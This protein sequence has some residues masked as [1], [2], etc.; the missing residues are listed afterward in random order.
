LCLYDR[1]LEPIIECS[2]DCKQ[3]AA[4][5]LILLQRESERF[6]TSEVMSTPEGDWTVKGFIDIFRNVYTISGD[7]KVVSKLIELMLFPQFLAFAEK[8]RLKVIPAP[9]QNYYPDLTFVDEAGCKFALDLKSAYRIDENAVNGMT[10]GAFTG[11]FRERHSAKNIAFPYSE[12]SGHFVL[13]VIYTRM[14]V[15]ADEFKT[16]SI[17]ELEQIPSVIKDLWF[18]VQPKYR[19]AIDRPGSGNTKNI[20]A[21]NKIAALVNGAGPFADLGEEIFD[22]YWMYY[23]TSDMARKAELPKPPYN[24]LAS[25]FAFKK[26]PA[27]AGTSTE[28][29]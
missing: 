15:R 18:F 4:M 5:F 14:E 1:F 19:I 20:G 8:H 13:G 21:T 27:N 9:E 22:D 11:Y 2:M 28:G 17:D 7:T 26:V 3:A 10:L 6:N 12:Y 29:K 23:L 24:N 16:H 25:Y